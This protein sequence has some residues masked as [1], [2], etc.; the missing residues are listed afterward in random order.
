MIQ[1]EG[2]P[3]CHSSVAALTEHWHFSCS[4]VDYCT[5]YQCSLQLVWGRQETTSAQHGGT[6]AGGQGSYLRTTAAIKM[7]YD[8]CNHTSKL[9]QSNIIIASSLHPPLSLPLFLPHFCSD[10]CRSSIGPARHF[11]KSRYH[12]Q[13]ECHS[14]R[15][16]IAWQRKHQLSPPISLQSGKGCRF[17]A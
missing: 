16:W 17:T 13:I 6:R 3:E 8:H 7:N 11:S 4:A 15:H 12:Q 14:C 9:T 5:G 2:L 1:W 10:S